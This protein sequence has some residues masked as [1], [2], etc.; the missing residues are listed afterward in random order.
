MCRNAGSTS[1]Y[2]STNLQLGSHNG[3]RTRVLTF[4]AIPG[5]TS[6]T[7][8]KAMRD[9]IWISCAQK[10]RRNSSLF[11]RS[12]G[13]ARPNTVHLIRFVAFCVRQG[14]EAT[15]G[16]YGCGTPSGCPDYGL[17]QP[18]RN[19]QNV[20]S[21]QHRAGAFKHRKVQPSSARSAGAGGCLLRHRSGAVHA[22]VLSRGIALPVGSSPVASRPDRKSV[23]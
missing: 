8:F 13:A 1:C 7:S 3:I 20:S 22:V 19:N 21:L 12:L 10:T 23:V 5:F 17:H 15:G 18:W 2:Q 11:L 16:A 4:V 14:Q 6:T 9:V